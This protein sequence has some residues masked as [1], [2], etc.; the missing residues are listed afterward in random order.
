VTPWRAA[1]PFRGVPR[2]GQRIRKNDQNERCWEMRGK[3]RGTS[4]CRLLLRGGKH[5]VHPALPTPPPLDVLW[6]PGIAT[7]PIL[8]GLLLLLLLCGPFPVLCPMGG[9]LGMHNRVFVFVI[10]SPAHPSYVHRCIHTY[11]RSR[12]ASYQ[13]RV[14]IS[15]RR[16]TARIQRNIVTL[17][18]KDGRK[19]ER[20]SDPPR[21]VS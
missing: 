20:S 7:E 18:Q 6:P 8:R 11:A 9:R 19:E 12:P 15:V 4:G 1:T 3:G 2:G 14:N 17:I 5:R 10:D 21:R 13:P 16:G